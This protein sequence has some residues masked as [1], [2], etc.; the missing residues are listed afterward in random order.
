M[1][2]LAAIT[3]NGVGAPFDEM[4]PVSD[5]SIGSQ[6]AQEAGDS[7]SDAFDEMDEGRAAYDDGTTEWAETGAGGSPTPLVQLLTP[8]NTPTDSSKMDL[9]IRV[10]CTVNDLSATVKIESPV[11]NVIATDNFALTTAAGWVTRQFNATTA[12]DLSAITNWS[13]VYISY[14]YPAT[15]SGDKLHIS[16]SSLKQGA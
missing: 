9:T 16:G 1:R 3:H 14:Q 2:S 10:K 12:E 6:W 13:D 11:G 8:S 7:D 5:Q 4:V 15:Q